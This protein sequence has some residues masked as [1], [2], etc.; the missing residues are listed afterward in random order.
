ML[1]AIGFGRSSN[2]LV[3]LVGVGGQRSELNSANKSSLDSLHRPTHECAFAAADFLSFTLYI[4]ISSLN[5]SVDVHRNMEI[6]IDAFTFS[7]M[8]HGYI[9]LLLPLLFDDSTMTNL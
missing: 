6:I 5:Q 3:S 7:P 2:T 1:P 9:F 8:R 4:Y